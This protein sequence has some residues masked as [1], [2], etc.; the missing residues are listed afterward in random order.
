MVIKMEK[1]I[2]IEFDELSKSVT[3]KVS[4]VCTDKDVHSKDLLDEAKA[5]YEEA[6]KYSHTKT[7]QKA[8]GR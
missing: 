6:S 7:L 1:T 3:A 2:K 5:L 4:I 8:L